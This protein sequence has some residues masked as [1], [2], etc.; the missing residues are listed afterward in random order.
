MNYR[1]EIEFSCDDTD[2]AVDIAAEM[3]TAVESNAVHV[4][5]TLSVAT[6]WEIGSSNY[7]WQ[8]V[9]ESKAP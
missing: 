9:T 2:L 7:Y 1:V 6:R 8:R 5:T 3:I 4:S